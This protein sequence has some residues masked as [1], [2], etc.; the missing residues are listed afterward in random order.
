[1]VVHIQHVFPVSCSKI[2]FTNR[3]RNCR[4]PAGVLF[5]VYWLKDKRLFILLP[6]PG[7]LAAQNRPSK[8]DTLKW[9]CE[10]EP[11]EKSFVA[12]L[13][14]RANIE[15]LC[16]QLIISVKVSLCIFTPA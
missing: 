8:S 14:R 11:R 6:H 16:G 13:I 3:F 4:S 1:M 7:N 9:I 5:E 10:I 15:I 12:E 2:V